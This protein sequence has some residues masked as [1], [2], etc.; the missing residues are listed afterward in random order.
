MNMELLKFDTIIDI[1]CKSFIKRQNCTFK[2]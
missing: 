1:G 2:A